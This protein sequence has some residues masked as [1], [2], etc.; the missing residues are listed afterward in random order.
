MSNQLVTHIADG[1]QN[2]IMNILAKC[3]NV[4]LLFRWSWNI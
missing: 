3:C 2:N 4:W 1:L